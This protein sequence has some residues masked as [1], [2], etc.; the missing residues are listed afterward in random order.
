MHLRFTV[1]GEPASKANSRRL[2]LHGQ[3][4]AFIKS[5]KALSYAQAFRLQCPKLPSP[6]VDDLAVWIRIHYASRRPDLDDSVILDAMQGLIYLNDRQ[7][8][9]RHVYWSLDRQRPRSDI[10]VATLGESHTV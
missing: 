2:V 9:E 4:P 6:W 7:V 1:Q 3:R 10:V 5:A 8:R